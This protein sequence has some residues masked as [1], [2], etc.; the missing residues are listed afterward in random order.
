MGWPILG[1]TFFIFK[2]HSP[3]PPSMILSASNSPSQFILLF[4]DTS[5]SFAL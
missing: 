1:S 3:V 4:K 5:K 2:R